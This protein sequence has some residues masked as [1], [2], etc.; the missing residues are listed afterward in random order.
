MNLPSGTRRVQRGGFVLGLIV[1][2]LLGLAVALGVALYIAKVPVPFVDKV[3]HRTAEQDAAETE[4]LKTWDPNAGLAGKPVPRPV[5]PA[6][7]PV[8]P[9]A[10]AASSAA[11]GA[12]AA[13]AA[14]VAKATRDPAAILA[15]EPSPEAAKVPA[16]APAPATEPFLYFVQAGAYSSAN[17]AEQQRARLAMLGLVAKVSER[18]QGGRA[19]H[20]VRLGPYDT[21]DEAENQL[22]RVKATGNDAVLRAERK[23]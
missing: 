2:L 10:A 22:E 9:V 15:G 23:Q 16:P 7:A 8:A 11:P 4:K 18:E 14:K 20:R 17:D 19:V 6:S 5:M 13:S 1:G 21:R 12:A 3:G